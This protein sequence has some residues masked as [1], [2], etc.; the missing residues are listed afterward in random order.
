V[1]YRSALECPKFH[2]YL[3]RV[4][5]YELPKISKFG[6]FAGLLTTYMVSWVN[7]TK[8]WYERGDHQSAT[9]CQISPVGY[10]DP[11]TPHTLDAR[12]YHCT[13]DFISKM[14]SLWGFLP[15]MFNKFD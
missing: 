8:I 1:D 12:W 13:T 11:T 6:Q 2:P 4:W 9:L 14:G 10:M 5:V 7:Q 3:Y 15:H